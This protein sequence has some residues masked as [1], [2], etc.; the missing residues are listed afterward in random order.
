[1]S[2]KRGERLQKAL[3]AAGLGSRRSVERLIDEGRVTVNGRHARLGTRVDRDNDKVE[4][5]GSPVPLRQELAYFLMNKP[6]GV[7]TTASDPHGRPTVLDYV[8][9]TDRVW[10]VGRLDIDTEGALVLTNDGELTF[11]LTHP[12]FR[13]DK[14][15]L[16]EVRGSLGGAAQGRLQRGVE[17]HDGITAPARVAVMDRAGSSSLV[18]ISIH[19]GRHRQ[20][21]RMFEAVGHP[22]TRLVRTGIGP[23]ALGRL[24][25]ETVRRLRP[26]EIASLYAACERADPVVDRSTR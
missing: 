1:M 3:A 25:P 10:P 22:V 20:I 23:L 8:P 21:R 19:E 11:R 6:V 18:E 12:S 16:A 5:D 13:I 7:V 26:V 14:T 9:T 4:V 15:Y 24:R 2:E 17:L